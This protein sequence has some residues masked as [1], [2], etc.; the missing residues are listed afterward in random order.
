VVADSTLRRRI[1]IR[2]GTT[3]DG[4]TYWVCELKGVDTEGTGWTCRYEGITEL[5]A[6]ARRQASRHRDHHVHDAQ[7]RNNGVLRPWPYR[8]PTNTVR[9]LGE[10]L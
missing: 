9:A 3:M 6:N 7:V 1:P 4:W 10:L 8:R 5:P 2:F